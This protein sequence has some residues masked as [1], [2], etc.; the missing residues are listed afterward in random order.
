M[1]APIENLA[2]LQAV[3]LERAR[4][5]QSA[6]ALPAEIAQ[7]E[8]ALAGAQQRAA[9]ASDALS[10][11]EALRNRLEREAEQ[12][13]QK[14]KRYRA[15]QDSVTTPAQAEAIE[16]E[17]RFAESEIERLDT[18]EFASL[19]RTETQEAALAAARV[20]VEE[21]AC[22]L[23]KT[24]ERIAARQKEIAA[25]LAT[26][27]AERG[28]LRALIEPGL[29]TRFDRIAASRGTGLARAE[30]QQCTG[31]R[32]GVRP[33]MWNQLREGELLTCDSCGRLLYW[34]QAIAPAA[35][36]PQTVTPATGDGRAIRKPHQAGA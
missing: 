33:Q 21:L 1:D 16:H 20:Q 3:D 32:M 31:C 25:A 24:Q 22:A 17:V 18:D 7:A 9:A 26:F 14:A 34:D 29:L 19:E 4:L 5:T 13:R 6:R 12:H 10:R 36:A 15:Q 28:G 2:K 11:E 23:D 30:N 27:E 8:A 35:K